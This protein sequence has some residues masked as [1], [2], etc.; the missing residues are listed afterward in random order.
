[1]GGTLLLFFGNWGGA[2]HTGM[3]VE[4]VWYSLVMLVWGSHSTMI[5]GLYSARDQV[6]IYCILTLSINVMEL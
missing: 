4:V 6:Q 3:E 1:M 5:E 2:T